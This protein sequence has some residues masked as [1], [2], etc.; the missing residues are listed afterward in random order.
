M[1]MTRDNLDKQLMKEIRSA[2]DRGAVRDF[3]EIYLEI[4]YGFFEHVYYFCS[5][6]SK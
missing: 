6:E 1:V 2:L 4:P 5:A 3:Q